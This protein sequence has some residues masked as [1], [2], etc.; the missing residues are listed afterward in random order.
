[1]LDPIFKSICLMNI[2]AGYE[3]ATILVVAYDEPMLLRLLMKVYK[4]ITTC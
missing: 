2:Y 4:I 3:N 1:M